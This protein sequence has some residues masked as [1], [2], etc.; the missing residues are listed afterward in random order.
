MPATAAPPQPTPMLPFFAAAYEHT[1]IFDD[2]TLTTSAAG[3]VPVGPVDIP[4]YGFLRHIWLRVDISGGTLG[5]G[6][7]GYLYPFNW[8]DQISL[9]DVNGSPLISPMSGE[10]LFLA[11]LF[12]G[13]VYRQDPRDDP[14]FVGT[15]NGTFI[16][17]LPV[18]ISHHDALGALANQSAQ[19]TYKLRYS[20]RQNTQPFST[21]PT[22]APTTVRVRAIL[23]AWS[24]PPATD[25]AGRP[26]MT[27][28]PR[29]GTTQFWST[30]TR[31]LSV[32]QNTI[33]MNRT[34][35]LIRNVILVF[36][37]SVGVPVNTQLPDPFRLSVDARDVYSD[38]AG[39]RTTRQFEQL[40]TNQAVA[41]FPAGVVGLVFDNSVLNKAGDG[42]PAAF[43]PTVQST[44]WDFIC[45][46]AA[47]GSVDII[48]NDVAPVETDPAAR[49]RDNATGFTP[50]QLTEPIPA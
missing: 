24:Q 17:R 20:I 14:N 50:G 27:V 48:V 25:P 12:G 33:T 1:E 44:R 22:T 38:F 42:S 8:L 10:Q 39:Y 13:Y 43:F 35:N 3:P 7:L 2:R 31:P 46:V 21:A 47:V 19:T 34:G 15:I 36:R 16:L 29:H 49:Y 18:E 28:P 9:F 40:E 11:N 6:V 30:Q 5:A 4:A 45:N 37:N 32:G 26:Q 23:E 41:N